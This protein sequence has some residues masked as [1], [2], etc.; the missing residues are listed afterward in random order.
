VCRDWSQ[1]RHF[2]L[3]RD[4]SNERTVSPEA[5]NAVRKAVLEANPE[6][7]ARTCEAL[8]DVGHKD[9]SYDVI[10]APAVFIAGDKDAI[11]PI[12]RSKDLSTLT[13]GKSWVEVVKSGHQPILE[14]LAGVQQAI[15]RLLRYVPNHSDAP[16]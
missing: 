7:Y 4:H 9:P 15:Q 14:D 1:C 13:S 2:T 16:C 10:V 12:A 6:A 5:R 8:V 3:T 11:S